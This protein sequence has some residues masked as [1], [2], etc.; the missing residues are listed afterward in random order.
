MSAVTIGRGRG[1]EPVIRAAYDHIMIQQS[2]RSDSPAPLVPGTAPSSPDRYHG[3]ALGV[4][5]AWPVQVLSGPDLQPWAS[6]G[7]ST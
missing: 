2:P 5:C 4:E 6:S 1:N 3:I 7:D